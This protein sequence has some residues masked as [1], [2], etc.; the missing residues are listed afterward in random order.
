MIHLPMILEMP[1]PEKKKKKIDRKQAD[2]VYPEN[3]L[4]KVHSALQLKE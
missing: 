2:I 1:I 3:N 4:L